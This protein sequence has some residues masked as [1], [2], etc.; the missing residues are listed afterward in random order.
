ME[1][2]LKD[3]EFK[4]IVINRVPEKYKALFKELSKEEFADDYGQCLRTILIDYF[5]Y[6]KLKEMFFTNKLDIEMIINPKKDIN[7]PNK[8]PTNLVGED[9]FKLKEVKNG[10]IK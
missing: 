1:H 4:G 5:E 3:I 6:Q 9:I 2:S 8:G 7:I 10:S